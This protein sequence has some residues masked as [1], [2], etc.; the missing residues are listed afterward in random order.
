[1]GRNTHPALTGGPGRAQLRCFVRHKR[2]SD[3][4]VGCLRGHAT[5]DVERN[6]AKSDGGS[7]RE[8]DTTFT[9]QSSLGRNRFKSGTRNCLDLLLTARVPSVQIGI[10]FRH[11]LLA[12][13]PERPPIRKKD[14]HKE[15]SAMT[16]LCPRHTRLIRYSV[17]VGSGEKL[18][19]R[20]ILS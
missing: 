15:T 13:N 2:H 19:L 16:H 18:A 11:R 20:P 17:M 6:S 5:N 1:M 10:E 8:R 7:K 4:V 12:Q 3:C 9:E 14:R